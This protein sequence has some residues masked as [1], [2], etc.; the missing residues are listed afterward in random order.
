MNKTQWMVM[1]VCFLVGML[2]CGYHVSSWTGVNAEISQMYWIFGDFCVL[3][4]FICLI[5]HGLEPK[6]KA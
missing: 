1:A 3:L 2:Y 6:K 5:M 4:M